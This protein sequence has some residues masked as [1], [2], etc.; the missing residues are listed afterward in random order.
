MTALN[1]NMSA[2]PV[3]DVIRKR[4]PDTVLAAMGPPAGVSDTD[5]QTVEALVGLFAGM[6][7]VAD[8]FKPDD[9]QLDTLR[10]GGVIEFVQYA[11]R[12]VMHSVSVWPAAERDPDTP[13]QPT[14]LGRFIL[15]A[16]ALIDEFPIAS[17]ETRAKLVQDLGRDLHALMGGGA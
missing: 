15:T 13:Q 10:D 16:S 7:A 8:Y 9:E 11:P 6:P 4:R 17:E 2:V 12:M 5:C 1:S 14:P 3:P